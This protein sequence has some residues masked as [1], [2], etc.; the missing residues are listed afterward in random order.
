MASSNGTE[1]LANQD[2][3]C[4]PGCVAHHDMIVAA[5]TRAKDSDQLARLLTLICSSRKPWRITDSQGRSILH[6]A[7]S[8]GKVDIMSW[9]LRHRRILPKT[10]SDHR[11]HT[12]VDKVDADS[13]WTSLHRSVFQGGM[14]H[15]I[16]SGVFLLI[17]S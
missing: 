11:R 17:Y 9:Y 13:G 12:I 8:L 4:L 7:A 16:L 1:C 15:T 10:S 14:L 3:E 6:L 2:T 5:V